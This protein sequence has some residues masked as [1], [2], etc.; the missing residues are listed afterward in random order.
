MLDPRFHSCILAAKCG[1][2]SEAASALYLSKQ[3]VKK[4]ID[5][6]ESELG[7]PI[8][9]R[10]SKGLTLTPAGKLFVEGIEKLSDQYHRLV[11]RCAFTTSQ[12][13]QKTLT[14]LQ[15]SHPRIYLQEAIMAYNAR[16]PE[17]AIHLADTRSLMVLYN[18]TGRLRTLLDGVT[19][20][21]LAPY[22]QKYDKEKLIFHKLT[23]LQYNCVM[24]P[25]HPLSRK[26]TVTR[27]DL[28]SWPV[29]INTIMD[30]DLYEHIMDQ[31]PDYLPEVISFAEKELS[32]LPSITSFCING[33]IFITK[34]SYL[35]TLR[36]LITRPFSPAFPVENGLYCRKDSPA[37]VRDFIELA[38]QFANRSPST[39]D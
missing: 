21:V 9:S 29:R 14:I 37:H 25:G 7:F 38:L 33:G 27:E 24:K 2:I 26:D 28:A 19:D 12:P 13:L 3:A 34:G 10:S 1:S 16:F 15:P 6:L 4:Q 5:S 22:E 35:H 30:R 11:D 17:V 18:S 36:P 8:F 20:I 39:F 23:D 31:Q 32:S